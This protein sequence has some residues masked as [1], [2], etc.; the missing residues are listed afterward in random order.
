MRKSLRGKCITVDHQAA[1]PA[2]LTINELADRWRVSRQTIFNM[3]RGG[4][5]DAKR[6]GRLVRIPASEV[7][8]VEAS[9]K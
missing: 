4:Q 5:I 1:L 6:F 3:R 2:F 9:F 8:R 7:T